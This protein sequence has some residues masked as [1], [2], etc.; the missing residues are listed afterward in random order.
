MQNTDILMIT[1]EYMLCQ[2]N[3]YSLVDWVVFY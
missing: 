3:E 2:D 1:V